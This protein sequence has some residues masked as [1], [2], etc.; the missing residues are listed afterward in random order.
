MLWARRKRLERDLAAARRRLASWRL[1]L[2]NHG[3]LAADAPVVITTL[4]GEIAALESEL[5]HAD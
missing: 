1:E 5:V 2:V 4:E 3:S